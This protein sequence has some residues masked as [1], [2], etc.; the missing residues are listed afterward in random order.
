MIGSTDHDDS[1][2]VNAEQA[3]PSWTAKRS[4]DPLTREGLRLFVEGCNDIS[5]L[6]LLN[7]LPVDER[8]SGEA[9]IHNH[10]VVAEAR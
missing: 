4:D 8:A 9:F 3:L 5:D 6:D 10:Q 7:R 1:A 2:C